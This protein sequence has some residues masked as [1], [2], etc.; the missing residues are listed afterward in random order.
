VA[1]RSTTTAGCRPG[2]AGSTPGQRHCARARR[3]TDG[4]AELRSGAASRHARQ[5]VSQAVS[6]ATGRCCERAAGRLAVSRRP[7]RA[8]RAARAVPGRHGWTRG[9][10]TPGEL[11]APGHQGPRPHA[12]GAA[13]PCQGTR[14]L[15][16][17]LATPA[18]LAAP[19]AMVS[20]HASGP[21]VV[22]PC[23]VGA[24]RL[25]SGRAAGPRAQQGKRRRDGQGKRRREREK[26]GER[27][28]AGAVGEDGQG[29][30]GLV[31]GRA[32]R[33]AAGRASRE[34]RRARV[35]EGAAT[36]LRCAARAAGQGDARGP[37][38]ASG[39]ALGHWRGAGPQEGSWRAR[40]GGYDCTGG[41]GEGGKHCWAE[42]KGASAQA[43]SWSMGRPKGRRGVDSL[44]YL[45]SFYLYFEF[46]LD[47]RFEI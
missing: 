27:G 19:R 10:A 21:G 38:Q 12:A 47:L 37:G 29:R 5:A 40:P 22:R 1:F 16:V 15:L 43:R 30:G 44:F 32:R 23:R 39:V 25:R 4:H 26:G 7:G 46:S 11:A 24:P 42:A 6:R 34:R 9:R 35:W 20:G 8:S 13:R 3:A 2:P 45:F 31:S 18:T 36:R 41:M 14:W 17:A 28:W 33:A